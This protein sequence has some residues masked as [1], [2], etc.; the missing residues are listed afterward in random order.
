MHRLGLTDK[1]VGPIFAPDEELLNVPGR[2]A[3]SGERIFFDEG[4]I[5]VSDSRIVVPDQTFAVRSISSVKFEEERPW[6]TIALT[7]LFAVVIWLAAL[8][9]YIAGAEGWLLAAASIFAGL[10]FAYGLS[11]KS[12]YSVV[13]RTFG[14]EVDALQ[15]RNQAYIRD[16]IEAINQPISCPLL[17]R[18]AE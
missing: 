6:R 13:L 10:L 2:S 1:N 12:R 5:F 17:V 4:G 11:R 15:S 3:P 16:V 18:G 8:G 9:G 14:G 7:S